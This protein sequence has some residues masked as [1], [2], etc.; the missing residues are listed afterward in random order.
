MRLLSINEKEK[1]Q[2]FICNLEN[3]PVLTSYLYLEINSN[4]ER[5]TQE[6]HF[7]I[8]AQQ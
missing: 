6:P 4:L 3:I 2:N 7:R 8:L 5:M 1:H